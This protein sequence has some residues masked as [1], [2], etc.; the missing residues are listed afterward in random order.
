MFKEI[1]EKW[2]NKWHLK[3]QWAYVIEAAG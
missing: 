3:G 2:K 1:F